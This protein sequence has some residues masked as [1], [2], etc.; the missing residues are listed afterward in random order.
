MVS[1]RQLDSVQESQTEMEL[2][3]DDIEGT[4]DSVTESDLRTDDIEDADDIVMV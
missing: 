2:R 3:T 1:R 4:D